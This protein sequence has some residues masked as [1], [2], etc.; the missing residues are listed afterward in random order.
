MALPFANLTGDPQQAYLADG[1]TA[2]ITADL[3]RIRDAV[4]VSTSTA[5]AYKD[6]AITARQVGKELGVRFVL[7]GGVQRSGNS[8]RIQAQLADTTTNAQLWSESFEGTQ[9]DLFALQ[10][11]VTTRIGNSIGQAMV[12]VAARDSEARKRDPTV[13]DLM[14]RA[15]AVTLKPESRAKWADQQPL[16][17]KA[18]LIEPDN[19]MVMARL[20]RA[21]SVEAWNGYVKDPAEREKLYTEARDLALRAKQLGGEDPRIYNVLSDFALAHGDLAEGI[22]LAEMALSLDPKRGNRYIDVAIAYSIA[23]DPARALAVLKRGLPLSERSVLEYFYALIG[24]SYFSIGNDDAAIEW[25]QKAVDANAGNTGS[26]VTLA[27]AYARKGDRQRSHAAVVEVLKRE[28]QIRPLEGS[29][30]QTREEMPPAARAIFD[31]QDPAGLA[32]GWI[33]RVARV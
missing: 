31:T 3:G 24:Q 12:I 21:L 33:A 20:A 26:L 7:Q 14:L 32:E 25:S 8:L 30:Y 5:F 28:P 29:Q 17:R 4:I 11:Q 13:A 23:G 27:L 15:E 9:G 10:D 19:P 18:L 2:A 6:K 1:L 16:L 22:R